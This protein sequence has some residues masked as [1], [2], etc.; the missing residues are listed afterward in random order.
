MPSALSRCTRFSS[1]PVDMAPTRLASAVMEVGIS[2]SI[3]SNRRRKPAWPTS[4]IDPRVTAEVGSP[5][6]VATAAMK[7][8][9]RASNS[10]IDIAIVASNEIVAMHEICPA[11]VMPKLHAATPSPIMF[12]GHAQEKLPSESSHSAAPGLH[13]HR[14]LPPTSDA[15]Q[16]AFSTSQLC[17]VG[18]H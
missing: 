4:R 13:E 15:E 6:T 12:A 1:K 5:A 7:L 17:H 18:E 16:T 3:A 2:I 8:V 9:R 11:H 10:A 14:K